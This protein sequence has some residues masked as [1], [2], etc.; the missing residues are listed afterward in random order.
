MSQNLLEKLTNVAEQNLQEEDYRGDPVESAK[1]YSDYFRF[2]HE[3][4][5]GLCIS[6]NQFLETIDVDSLPFGSNFKAA[7]E[8]AD[9]VENLLGA[10]VE[11]TPDQFTKADEE[12]KEE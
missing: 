3:K 10:I 12:V 6:M 8:A 7:V 1:F 11:I 4:A 9:R 5:R 2:F